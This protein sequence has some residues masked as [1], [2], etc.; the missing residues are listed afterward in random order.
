MMYHIRDKHHQSGEDKVKIKTLVYKCLDNQAPLYLQQLIKYQDS[1]WPQDQV[2]EMYSKYPKS[3]GK[4][5]W[6]SHL[7]SEVSLWFVLF[8]YD[9]SFSLGCIRIDL[10]V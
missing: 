5:F 2:T 1:E 7:L 9:G 3:K 6:E 4:H 10:R 8:R